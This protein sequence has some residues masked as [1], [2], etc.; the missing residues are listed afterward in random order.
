MVFCP[1]NG[2]K[3][4]WLSLYGPYITVHSASVFSYLIDDKA[5]CHAQTCLG[6]KV[7]GDH[8][9]ESGLGEPIMWRAWIYHLV[10][11]HNRAPSVLFTGLYCRHTGKIVCKCTS[12]LYSCS[13]VQHVQYLFI[14]HTHNCQACPKRPKINKSSTTVHRNQQD[15]KHTHSKEKGCVT[16]FN[17]KSYLSVRDWFLLGYTVGP[18]L[19]ASGYCQKP[20][21]HR[22]LTW[23]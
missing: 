10:H 9:P 16:I 18:P 4:H 12:T 2:S 14:K 5:A 13:I 3:Q 22:M 17:L 6:P 23:N 8:D 21:T 11:H 7:V 19:S 20:S 15:C 1:Y